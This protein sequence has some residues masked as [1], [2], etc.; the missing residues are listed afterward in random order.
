MK[1]WIFVNNKVSFCTT[2]AVTLLTAS[3]ISHGQSAEDV[4]EEITVTGSYIKGSSTTGA[5]PITVVG[6]NDI[7]ALG[8]PTT[9]SRNA[10]P[11]GRR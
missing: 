2:V 11:L 4:L 5:L 3:G 1:S 10:A 7:E 8:A 9:R 6:R